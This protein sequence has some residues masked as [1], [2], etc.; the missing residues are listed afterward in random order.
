VTAEQ[1]REQEATAEEQRAR[2]LE[3]ILDWQLPG[4]RQRGRAVAWRTPEEDRKLI[5]D[6]W[7]GR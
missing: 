6:W 2:N 7:F 5:D 1:K 3:T 4:W